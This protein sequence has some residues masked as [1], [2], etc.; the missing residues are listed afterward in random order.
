MLFSVEWRG[1]IEIGS[2]R[3]RAWSFRHIGYEFVYS[4]EGVSGSVRLEVPG[5][6]LTL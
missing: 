2:L 5:L 4:I 1:K 6:I 3:C